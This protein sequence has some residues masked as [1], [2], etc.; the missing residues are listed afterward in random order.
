MGI[1]Y[2]VPSCAEK[3]VMSKMVII[4]LVSKIQLKIMFDIVYFS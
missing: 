1:K 3:K 4:K 2:M